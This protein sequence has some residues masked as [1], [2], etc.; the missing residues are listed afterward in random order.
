VYLS[1]LSALALLDP[2]A[3]ALD[4]STMHKAEHALQVQ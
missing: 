3:L 4:S 2:G 1:T